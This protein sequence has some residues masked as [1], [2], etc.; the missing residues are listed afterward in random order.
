MFKDA[1]YLTINGAKIF[2]EKCTIGRLQ[3]EKLMLYVCCPTDLQRNIQCTSMYSR[4]QNDLLKSN[5]I[6]VHVQRT[7]ILQPILKLKSHPG[8]CSKKIL[9]I[10]P[11]RMFGVLAIKEN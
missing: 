1:K 2:A 9:E 8:T 11:I 10:M 3:Q 6:Y 7:Y 4:F 5:S